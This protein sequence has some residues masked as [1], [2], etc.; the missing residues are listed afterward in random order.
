MK[1][2]YTLPLLLALGLPLSAAQGVEDSTEE[3]QIEEFPDDLWGVYGR[4]NFACR[5]KGFAV[6]GK[7]GIRSNKVIIEGEPFEIGEVLSQS[8]RALVGEFVAPGGWSTKGVRMGF[9]LLRKNKLWFTT[10]E[11]RPAPKI[12]YYRCR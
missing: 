5:A 6:E 7:I 9:T 12:G 11:G 10:Y 4:N 2:V 8:D 3:K 1:R